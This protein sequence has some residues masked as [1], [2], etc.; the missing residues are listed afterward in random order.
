MLERTVKAYVKKYLNEL[1][2]YHHWPV[3]SGYGAACLDCHGCFK[4]LYF[5]VETKR[6][7]KRPTPLQEATISQIIAAGG[8]VVVIDTPEAALEFRDHLKAYAETF[9][10]IHGAY[11][12]AVD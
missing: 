9:S 3:Q 11:P 2:A 6:P 7:G 5:A 1:G 4:G 10:P 8:V 12:R